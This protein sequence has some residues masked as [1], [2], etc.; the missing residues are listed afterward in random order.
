MI[1]VIGAGLAGSEAA[2]YLAQN[3]AD[4]ELVEQ[5]PV[6]RSP[7]HMSNDFC[8]LVCSNSLKSDD[9]F[10]NACG[11]LKEEMRRLG[12]LT[13]EA[14]AA[15]RVPAG[16]A[17]A[18]DRERFS[19]YVTEKLRTH[20]KIHIACREADSLPESGIVATG[21]L[22]DGA[23]YEA[24]AARFGGG[25]HFYDATAP[26]V[27]AESV[28]LSAAFTADRYGRGTGDYVNC[29]MNKEEYETFV[30]ELL[31]AEKVTLRDFEK[32]EI[33]EGCMPVEVMASRGKDSLRFGTFKP[34]GLEDEDGK[35][36]YAVLQLRR[37][38]EEGTLLGL[39]GCQTNLKFG[40]QKRVFSLIPAL[41]NAEF[42]RYGVMHRNTFLDSPHVLNHDFSAKDNKN[43]FFA[44]QMTGV[45]GY[46]ES[47]ASGM[48]A[49]INCF[50]RM[51]G[52]ES[53]VPE[54]TCVCGALARYIA[55]ENAH[56]QP[57]NANYG[58]LRSMD[59]KDKKQ[60]KKLMAERALAEIDRIRA[61]LCE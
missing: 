59:V 24:I 10:G 61:Q 1:T 22:T 15:T 12:S 19:A 58:I 17:L 30:R 29:P 9:V 34:V 16:G 18:V 38:N 7:A 47:A 48:L 50:R 3:G 42:V 52:K 11:L 40:E 39:V 21:P 2:W 25:L 54:D 28:D 26:V 35:R 44:G 6:R 31:S 57:M 8:E 4:V 55:T 46:V 49:A 27:T 51:Q 23:L 41:R 56:F 53:I 43:L 36:P 45:E 5:K 60:K 37:E 33:F 13:M 20:P 32:R 14:A